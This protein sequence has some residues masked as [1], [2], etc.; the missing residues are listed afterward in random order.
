M[1][2]PTKETTY[3][4]SSE[5]IKSEYK[6]KFPIAFS[7]S[8]F[9]AS[10]GIIILILFYFNRQK[11]NIA[12]DIKKDLSVITDL[13]VKQIE[14]WRTER[15][16]DGQMI[17]ENKIMINSIL[18]IY[19]DP[20]KTSL[21][22][23]LTDL[24]KSICDKHNYIT[25]RLV[26]KE[27]N[28]I[29]A[30]PYDAIMVGKNGR[31]HIQESYNS[32]KPLLSEFHF[33]ENTERIHIDLVVPIIVEYENDIDI[34]ILL[35]IDPY[36]N[37]YSVISTWP[38]E[39]KTAETLLIK[40]DKDEVVFLNE[41]RH[42]KNTALKLKIP[43]TRVL[44]PAVK[45]VNGIT[46]VT[47]GIDYRDIP[48]I[49]NIKPIPGTDW[50]MVAKIDKDEVFEDINRSSIAVTG[51]II[52][53]IIIA[54]FSIYL[55]WSKQ[56]ERYLKNLVD[57]DRKRLALIK[58]FD[59][60]IKNAN[61]IFILYDENA[62]V[63]EVNE[64]AI[65][66]YGYTKEEFLNLDLN[67]LRAPDVRSDV[68]D[69]IKY[70]KEHPDGLLLETRHIKKDRTIFPVESSTR[71]LQLGDKFYFQ[72]VVRDISERKQAE[73]ALQESEQKF[74]TAFRSSPEGIVIVS[75]KTNKIIDINETFSRKIGF[76]RD[77]MI[78]KTS[79]E[80]DIYVDYK[81]REQIF[82]KALE[83]GFI[84]GAEC[85]FKTKSGEIL[86]CLMSVVGVHIAGEQCFIVSIS[87]ITSIKKAE[88]KIEYLNR[89]YALLSQINQAIVR[90]DNKQ[91]LFE[92]ICS[93]AIEFGKF[94]FAWIGLLDE[95][96]NRVVPVSYDGFENGYLE[97]VKNATGNNV[98][99]NP[100]L[101]KFFEDGVNIVSNDISKDSFHV[102]DREDALKR[103][104]K[105]SGL[106]PIRENGKVIGLLCLSSDKLNFFSN[107]E[108]RL[109]DEVMMDIS[110][111]LDYY[112]KEAQRKDI[113]E[114]LQKSER[115]FRALFDSAGDAILLLDNY[116]F[117]E[118]N[119]VAEQIYGLDR[120]E[121]LFRSP[122]ELSPELQ[123]GGVPS[124]IKGMEFMNSAFEGKLT[125][126]EWLHKKSDGSTFETEVTLNSV[127]IG[128][129]KMLLAVVRDISERKKYEEGLKA[130]KQ[131]AEEM[132]RVKSNFLAN[133]SHELRTPM[134]GILG[135]ADILSKSLNDP[136]QRDMA[137]VI[138]KGG[139]RLTNTLNMILDLSK[140][141]AEK[142]DVELNPTNLSE[143]IINSVKLFE[144][145]AKVKNILLKAEI[146][147]NIYSLV[148]DRLFEQVLSNLIKNALIYTN[149]G[150]ITVFLSKK[151]INGDE[152]AEIK[153][154]DTGIGIPEKSL[155]LIFEPFRQV[156]EG[157]TRTFEGTGLGLTISKKY[158]E[159]M[160][161]TICVESTV[162]K[163]TTFSIYFKAINENHKKTV[164]DSTGE[165]INSDIIL[166]N[167]K[168]TLLVEDDELTVFTITKVLKNICKIDITNNGY[169]A[170]ELARKNKYDLILMDIGLKGMDGVKATK[171]IRKIPG[172][173][174]TPIIA[175]TAYAMEGDKEKFFN[176]GC[177]H[178]ISKPFS[179]E[180]L[181]KMIAEL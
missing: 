173:E 163:G 38:A 176:G 124:Q 150:T 97:I 107:E 34:F 50:F 31:K 102:Y 133:M 16:L 4:S 81:K 109:L 106:F 68:N 67:D 44:V 144:A 152:F 85:D 66:V 131:K 76:N 61:D 27:G 87:D 18:S 130:A 169:Q 114:A 154:V 51:L 88:E 177:S 53:V 147:E 84:Y 171:E 35:E 39:S 48:V 122:I 178:Y 64:K 14:N 46:G 15:L 22:N 86:N 118:F 47:D 96:T 54:G 166:K 145:N 36:I 121:L 128:S 162:N 153:V 104:Y 49:A 175:I 58:H 155:D 105:S 79:Q 82:A 157:W 8:L 148:D 80:L 78:G 103:G 158:V 62:R 71:F 20:T 161:G 73:V 93:I 181:R 3:L 91:E 9:L 108:I 2:K 89:I 11:E 23:D 160:N 99:E 132:N 112:I 126:F 32:R 135:F 42:L 33:Y 143:I 52:F 119:K 137:D 40:K 125:K 21:R 55:Y 90:I 5:H 60:I 110:F 69:T 127:Y 179:N 164:K 101:I 170:I 17:S 165:K 115:K 6:T 1:I 174:D 56:N 113:N 168:N 43:L 180:V 98:K 41:L 83:K 167:K 136:E 77:E 94:S 140:I 100:F 59:N 63:V 12:T 120:N 146:K 142:V 123:L 13:K 25:A 159:L 10:I 129:V 57:S 117:I 7:I 134:T 116:K 141:E 111:A 65:S 74:S 30:Y 172:Y 92:K 24:L 29:V 28:I 95:K 138:Y 139:K 149:E 19:K 26:D 70:V 151:K 75:S 45:A 72:S 37:L 156:S